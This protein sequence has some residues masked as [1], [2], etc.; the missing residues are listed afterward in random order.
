MSSLP[1]PQYSIWQAVSAALAI[2]QRALEEVRALSR[3]PG[4]QGERGVDGL[5]FDDLERID[6]EKQFGF[7]LVRGSEVKEFRWD[8]PAPPT[9]AD[10]YQGIWN[11]SSEYKRGN[12]VTCGGSSFLALRDGPGKPETADCGWILWVKR[13]RDGK[14]GKNGE[15]GLQGLQGQR[16]EPGPRGYGG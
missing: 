12:V 8:K 14:D 16:G 1:K 2:G 10:A 9:L 11:A 6:E 4:P 15:R 13:G 3:E 5:G 7:R